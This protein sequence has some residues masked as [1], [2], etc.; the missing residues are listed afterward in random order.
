MQT[1]YIATGV[2]VLVPI[3][4]IVIFQKTRS[5]VLSKDKK[6]RKMVKETLN[7]STEE[8]NTHKFIT[9][10][11]VH[12][13]R[14]SFTYEVIEEKC[15]PN[16]PILLVLP[17]FFQSS[18]DEQLQLYIDS[19][20]KEKTVSSVVIV[21]QRGIFEPIST[22]CRCFRNYYTDTRDACSIINQAENNFIVLAFRES[23]LKGLLLNYD[24]QA[25]KIE[26]IITINADLNPI[27][28]LFDGEV[29]D[30]KYK[31]YV[32]FNKDFILKEII[33]DEKDEE[34]MAKLLKDPS[35]QTFDS[36]FLRYFG[37]KSLENFYVSCFKQ[38]QFNEFTLK[39]LMI[40]EQL[41][42]ELKNQA[43]QVRRGKTVDEELIAEIAAKWCGPME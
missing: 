38:L 28:Y 1:K 30:E 5:G 33:A 21:H 6:F 37:K 8:S 2:L 40:G 32:Q 10:K 9:A 17:S 23:A 15:E 18:E 42:K 24:Q 25:S 26:R 16:K 27:D 29:K 35:N 13:E 41:V 43:D 36:L 39:W 14:E 4:A 3:L 20:I 34:T 7:M 31:N 12:S 19:F 22:Q 11:F